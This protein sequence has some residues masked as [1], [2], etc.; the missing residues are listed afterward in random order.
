MTQKTGKEDNSFDTVYR[1]LFPTIFRVA[2]RI[3]GDQG[4]AEDLCHEAFIKYLERPKQLPDIDQTKY[5]LIRVVKNISLNYEKRKLRERVAYEKLKK[6]S[7]TFAES[8]DFAIFRKE[9]KNTVQRML[10][11][12]PYQLRIVLILKEYSGLTYKEIGKV[13][14]IREGNVKVRVFRAREKLVKIFEE[15]KTHVP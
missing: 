6:I 15:R 9:T 1:S 7:P 3:V 5:W 10:S 12:L 11:M 13:L 14:G 2:Y 8:A 4:L